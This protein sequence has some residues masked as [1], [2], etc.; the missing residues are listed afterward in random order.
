MVL[1]AEE[2]FQ[3][4]KYG[5]G[6]YKCAIYPVVDPFQECKKFFLG[7]NWSRTSFFIFFVFFD[8]NEPEPIQTGQ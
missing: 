6:E 5:G 4:P 2:W 7:Y 8:K 1:T 3:L